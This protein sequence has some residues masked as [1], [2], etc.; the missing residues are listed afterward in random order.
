MPQWKIHY[1][2]NGIC[3]HDLQPQ[4][5]RHGFMK[6]YLSVVIIMVKDKRY[7]IKDTM[8]IKIGFIH[9]II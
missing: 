6:E 4:W 9:C 5:K 2:S 8:S 1:G 7:S 3:L